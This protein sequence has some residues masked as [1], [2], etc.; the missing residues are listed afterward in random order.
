MRKT[1]FVKQSKIPMVISFISTI[2]VFIVLII[3]FKRRVI[4]Y[5]DFNIINIIALSI[6][7]LS[8]IYSDFV[9]IMNFFH[10]K[11]FPYLILEDFSFTIRRSFPLK[12]KEYMICDITRIEIDASPVILV[13]VNQRH[14]VKVSIAGRDEDEW[15]YVREYF[16]NIAE[17]LS[18]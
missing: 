3:L 15:T 8:M 10:F 6:P 2:G 12:S 16:E 5:S 4:E 13:V 14:E 11:K 17:Q 18:G 1:V 7:L 9:S